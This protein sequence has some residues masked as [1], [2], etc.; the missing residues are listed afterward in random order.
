MRYKLFQFRKRSDGTIQLSEKD[1][2]EEPKLNFGRSPERP[3]ALFI[4]RRSR[5]PVD[6]REPEDDSPPHS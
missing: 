5:P 1:L 2:D 6:T 3:P 4:P